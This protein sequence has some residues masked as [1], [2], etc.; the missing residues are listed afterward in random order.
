M[1]FTWPKR[2]IVGFEVGQAVAQIR[3]WNF[4]WI[5][6]HSFV[7]ESMGYLM[8]YISYRCMVGEN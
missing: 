5:L 7:G 4:D 2:P 6:G 8:A 3:L 1:D